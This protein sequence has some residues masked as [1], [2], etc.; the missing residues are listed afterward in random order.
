MRKMMSHADFEGE[1]T[2]QPT[3]RLEIHSPSGRPPSRAE[4]TSAL[5]KLVQGRF[6]LSL[7]SLRGDRVYVVEIIPVASVRWFSENCQ[8][9]RQEA[10]S[11]NSESVAATVHWE[12]LKRHLAD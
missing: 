6:T 11:T 3:A 4:I 1:R 5:S 7:Q 2:S 8:S 10:P 9:F 12:E